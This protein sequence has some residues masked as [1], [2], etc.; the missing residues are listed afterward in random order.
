M[1]ARVRA[2]GSIVNGSQTI[3]ARADSTRSSSPVPQR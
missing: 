3:T 2:R 1:F